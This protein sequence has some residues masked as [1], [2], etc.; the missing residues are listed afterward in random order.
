[1]R[2]V[3]RRFVTPREKSIEVA[4]WS[5]A[6]V[7]PLARPNVQRCVRLFTRVRERTRERQAAVEE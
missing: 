6:R 5:P 4:L 3:L 7:K 1:M 2:L